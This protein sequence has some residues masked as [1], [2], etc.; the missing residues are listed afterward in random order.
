MLGSLVGFVSKSEKTQKMLF[1]DIDPKKDE[2][3]GDVLS[4]KMSQFLN[5]V[6]PEMTNGGI[7]GKLDGPFGL[8]GGMAVGTVF[9]YAK[10]SEKTQEFL[11][12]KV[13]PGTPEY[14]KGFI[15]RKKWEKACI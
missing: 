11:F 1:G 13:G 15:Y 2:Y 6:A 4:P 12:G 14:K 10:K 8:A 5:Q 7:V 9:V 3:S